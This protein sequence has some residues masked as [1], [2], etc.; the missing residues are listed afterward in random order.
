MKRYLILMTLLFLILPYIILNTKPP[1]LKKNKKIVKYNT[2]TLIKLK[3]KENIIELPLEK[4]IIGVVA[5]E[6]P[7]SYEKEALKAQA[8]A[9]RTYALKKINNGAEYMVNDTSNQVYVSEDKMKQNWGDKYDEYHKKISDA[10]L[11]TL[12]EV[13]KYD[14]DLIDVFFFSTSSGKTANSEEIFQSARPYLKSVDSPWDK[15]SPVF[16][17][18]KYFTYQEFCVNMGIN[19]SDKPNIKLEGNMLTI[20]DKTFKITEVRKNLDLR[21]PFFDINYESDK[22]KI[23]TYGYGHGVGMSQYGANGMAKEGK[24]YDEIIK[25][26]FQ[27]TEISKL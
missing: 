22:I 6:M 8:V 20:N 16:K 5:A 12:G 24:K 3:D 17:N 14:S 23:D 25:Y 15:T 13:I 27:N 7:A 26:Y 2:N 18:T 19:C 11:N 4:Y 21:S 1:H 10:V 9:A